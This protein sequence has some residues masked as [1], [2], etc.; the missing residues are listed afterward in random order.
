MSFSAKSGVWAVLVCLAFLASVPGLG[1]AE[2][3]PALRVCTFDLDVTPP[4]G[5]M[6]AYDP[7]KGTWDMG[8]RARGVVLLG[9]GEPMVLCAVDWIGISNG[10]HDAFREALAEAAG[11]VPDR[12]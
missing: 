9:A 7:V 3:V 5:S 4:V 12:V 6:M 2:E 10:A 11:T 8:L 1:A